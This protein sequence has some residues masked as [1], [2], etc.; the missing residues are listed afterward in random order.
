MSCRKN[1][2]RDRIRTYNPLIQSHP[3][4]TDVLACVGR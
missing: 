1:G 3:A 2:W 4:L